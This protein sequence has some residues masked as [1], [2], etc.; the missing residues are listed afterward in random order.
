LIAASSNILTLS[1]NPVLRN[2]FTIEEKIVLRVSCD[3]FGRL[4]ILNLLVNLFVISALPPDG[5][6]A[7]AISVASTTSFHYQSYLSKRPF[8]S[9]KSLNNSIG[10]WAPYVSTAGILISSTNTAI[11]FPAGGPNEVLD[12]FSSLSWIVYWVLIDVV[13][14]DMLILIGASVPASFIF[15]RYVAITAVL[16]TPDPPVKNRGLWIVRRASRRN[17]YLVVS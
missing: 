3:D 4:N 8:L 6:A 5:G 14:A 12:F 16:P 7:H 15:W 10:G 11:V 17:E 2:P 1:G 13:Y 9:R